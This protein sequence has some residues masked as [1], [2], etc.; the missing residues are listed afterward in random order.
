MFSFLRGKKKLHLRGLV[1]KIT[2]YSHKKLRS[3]LEESY[4]MREKMK[5]LVK[6]NYELGLIHFHKGN[7]YDASLRFRIVLCLDPKFADAH[8]NLGR[9]LLMR[10][11]VEKAEKSFS[12]ARRI[13]PYFPEIDY[14]LAYVQQDKAA[15]KNIPRSIIEEYFDDLASNY[16]QEYTKNQH[17]VGHRTLI[18]SV[19]DVLESKSVSLD[20][21]DLGCGTGLCGSEA[22]ERIM[23][24]TLTGVDVSEKMLRESRRR[25]TNKK[26]TYDYLKHQDMLVFLQ[27]NTQKYDLIIA[28][29]SFNYIGELDDL[30]A[31][32]KESLRPHGILAFSTEESATHDVIMN[33]AMQN[34]GHSFEYIREQ[35]TLAGLQE[36]SLRKTVLMDNFLAVQCVLR[37]V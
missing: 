37:K 23:I 16:N 21:L 15:I 8:Y 25:K 35:A 34:F 12:V 26:P 30:L 33:D 28:A 10:G 3:F 13:Q 6:T 29:L 22:R 17:Y 24:N 1:S 11:K 5:D 32:C 19:V 7:L 18:D 31:A 27:K 20:V 14:M 4:V 36:L 2:Q 9:T